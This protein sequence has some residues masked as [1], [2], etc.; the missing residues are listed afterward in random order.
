MATSRTF[1]DVNASHEV[2][3]AAISLMRRLRP[4]AGDVKWVSEQNLHWTLQFLGEVNDLEIPKLC[5]RVAEAAVEIEPFDLE[6]RGAGA[7]PSADRPR[8]LWLGAGAGSNDMVA[9]H[10][11][12]DHALGELGFRGESRRY[13][14]H[15]TLG[16]VGSGRPPD[17]LTAEL[18]ALADFQ[19]GSMLV[20]EVTLYSS[21]P[22][23]QG[24]IY[25]VLSHAPL[26][27]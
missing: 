1:I 4:S 16:R 14:P 11:A 10:A 27:P 9:L 3:Q 24:P 22:T 13:V 23:R 2:R 21:H 15:L 8:T 19:A 26:A 25:D 18:A 6:A 17:L 5:D 20:D 7:F 12:L